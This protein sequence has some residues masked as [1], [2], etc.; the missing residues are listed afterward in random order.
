M[1]WRKPRRGLVLWLPLP[2]EFE[3]EAVFDEAERRGVLVGPSALYQVEAAGTQ[4]IRLTYCA[5]P[6]ERLAL[7]AKRLGEALRAVAKQRRPRLS[8]IDLQAV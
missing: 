3:S 7:G 4:G 6:P 5:E 1:T 2:A 8:G